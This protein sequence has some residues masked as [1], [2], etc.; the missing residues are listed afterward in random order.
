MSGLKP[1]AERLAQKIVRSYKSLAEG[2]RLLIAVAGPPGAGK[3]TIA[4]PLTDR[5]NTLLGTSPKQP[6]S[7]DESTGLATNPPPLI[8]S[9]AVALCIG[10]DGF[11]LTREQLGKLPDAAGALYRRV[12]GPAVND[13]ES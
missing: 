3:S 10:M 5:I 12:C 11:H 13:A 2:H 7:V 1:D 9:R 6:S 8:D 4:Y